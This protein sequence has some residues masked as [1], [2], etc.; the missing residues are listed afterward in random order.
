MFVIAASQYG[1]HAK[2]F[3]V[4]WF[5]PV[6]TVVGDGKATLPGGKVITIDDTDPATGRKL[7]PSQID[8]DHQRNVPIVPEIFW[9]RLVTVAILVPLI[10]WSVAELLCRVVALQQRSGRTRRALR[11]IRSFV[12]RRLT[13]RTVIAVT[14]LLLLASWIYPP[15][16]LGGYRNLS[17]GWFFVFDTTRET[18][19]RVDFGR[20]FLIDAIIVAIG[21]LLA[22]TISRNSTARHVAVRVAFYALFVPPL[23]AVVCLGA[24]LIGNAAKLV[25]N[26]PRFDPSKPYEVVQGK[27]SREPRLQPD[28]FEQNAPGVVAP[29]DL[30]KITLF[31]VAPVLFFGDSSRLSAFHGRVRNDLSRAVEKIGLKASFYTAR[32]ELIE[33]RTFWMLGPDWQ[34][35]ASVLPNSPVCFHGRVDVEHLPVGW[36][37]RLEVI[38][39]QYVPDIFDSLDT[40]H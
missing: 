33:V 15:W 22:W 13:T 37:Y 38:E 9:F 14:I 17:H 12:D 5:L 2:G 28:W 26:K 21:G 32:R 40:S 1:S 4:Y 30:K 31:D 24:V 36:T 19:M 20:L 39:T 10:V 25:T 34:N 23:I 11:A 7:E 6:G 3:F 29:D 8:W 35:L 27:T 18:A 16:I